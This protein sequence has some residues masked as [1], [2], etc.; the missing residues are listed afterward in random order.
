MYG[1]ADGLTRDLVSIPM[2]VTLVWEVIGFWVIEPFG[3][4]SRVFFKAP[5]LPTALRR[6]FG[7]QGLG[8]RV[9][10]P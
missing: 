1:Q 9:P 3:F 10:K 8:L 4:V 5:I 7:F 6:G 2:M